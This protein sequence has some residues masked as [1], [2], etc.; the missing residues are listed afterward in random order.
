L[1]YKES[2]EH[3]LKTDSSPVIIISPAENPGRD[4]RRIL[5]EDD[6][7]RLSITTR[8]ELADYYLTAYRYQH[9][10]KN[11]SSF[12]NIERHGIIASVYDLRKDKIVLDEKN[13]V[14][15]FSI[16]YDDSSAKEKNNIISFPTA[17]SGNM[18]ERLDSTI[19]FGNAAIIQAKFLKHGNNERSYLKTGIYVLSDNPADFR[20]VVQVDS[21]NGEMK[22]WDGNDFEFYRP[23]KWTYL[24]W[25]AL[26]PKSLH[27]TDL[28]KVYL[29][30]YRKNIFFIDDVRVQIY[31][32]NDSLYQRIKTKYPLAFYRDESND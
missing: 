18:V 20:L 3:I 10:E 28:I 9:D 2:L 13:R 31:S 30:N 24:E 4:N 15:D 12:F 6:K 19:E 16:S 23:G 17:H 8:V 11:Y 25:N 5:S 26:L 22:H 29:W 32:V 7:S 21:V 27:E 1:S 14:V